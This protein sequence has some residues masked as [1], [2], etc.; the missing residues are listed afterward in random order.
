MDAELKQKLE[1]IRFQDKGNKKARAQYEKFC[2]KMEK[3]A[4]KIFRWRVKPVFKKYEKICKEHH[5]RFAYLSA[6]YFVAHVDYFYNAF[7]VG[8]SLAP[9]IKSKH[10]YPTF[11]VR[12]DRPSETDPG[13]RT[14]KFTIES[15]FVPARF[16]AGKSVQGTAVETVRDTGP[17]ARDAVILASG[18][19]NDA[20]SKGL[21][22]DAMEVFLG[23]C[24]DHSLAEKGSS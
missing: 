8:T 7:F 13:G 21:V 11:L 4:K 19:N 1:T 18:A 9:N 24:L 5:I 12:Y 2:G 17:E 14:G 23:A 6:V 10:G 15:E 20:I 3:Q 22:T 16:Y